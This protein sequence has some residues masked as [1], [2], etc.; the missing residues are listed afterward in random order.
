MDT[1]EIIDALEEERERLDRA[2]A[3]LEGIPQRSTVGPP[4]RGT[5]RVSPE[6]RKKIAE[7]QRR[8]W[9]KVKAKQAASARGTMKKK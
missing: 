8:R 7:A 9:A 6:A 1:Q 4:R 3:A 5:R 2:L